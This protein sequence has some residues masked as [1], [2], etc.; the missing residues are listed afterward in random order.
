MSELKVSVGIL[1]EF[2][3]LSGEMTV[4]R[5]MINK[6]VKNL[7]HKYAGDKELNHLTELLEELH[8]INGGIQV[9]ITDL[10][11]E[12]IQDVIDDLPKWLKTLTAESQKSVSIETLGTDLRVDTSIAGSLSAFVKPLIQFAVATT[13]KVA[14]SGKM[15]LEF[16]A[17]GENIIITFIDQTMENGGSINHEFLTGWQ[18]DPDLAVVVGGL[19][20]IG[21]G[22]LVEPFRKNAVKWV[23]RIPMPKS[24]LITHCLFVKGFSMEIGVPKDN[25]LRIMKVTSENRSEILRDLVDSKVL[26]LDGHILPVLNL[27]EILKQGSDTHVPDEDF[28]VVILRTTQNVKFALVV[29]EVVDI[30][31]AVVK[32]LSGPIK[33]IG[34]Y[35]GATFLG[36]GSLGL[37]MSVDGFAKNCG[38][39]QLA[40]QWRNNAEITRLAEETA[41]RNTITGK[42]RDIMLFDLFIQGRFC[43][44]QNDIFRLEEFESQKVQQS[45]S[46]WVV[47][48]RDSYL[49]LLDLSQWLDKGSPFDMSARKAEERWTTIVV[50]KGKLYL[51][52]VVKSITDSS[53]MNTEPQEALKKQR[54]V[55]GHFLLGDKTVAFVDIPALINA[56]ESSDFEEVEIEPDNLRPRL[57]KSA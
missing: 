50:Q 29:D 1:D 23:L 34:L 31:D 38:L 2:M 10:R 12:A 17:S 43:I 13:Y 52:F 22:I 42:E 14:S 16:R 51:G 24:V 44:L 40:D 26:L 45:G 8:K 25:I 9:K 28:N 35:L 49:T 47:P 56:L 3:L 53:Q 5:N 15:S 32:Q 27:S 39:D 30:E 37:I 54:G 11:K 18:S 55:K 36:E 6:M 7:E 19:Q 21:G 41:Q 46:T 4:I 33:K 48:Y 20:A 57:V